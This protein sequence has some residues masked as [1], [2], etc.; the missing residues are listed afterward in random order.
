MLKKINWKNEIQQTAFDLIASFGW[1]I[2]ISIFAAPNEI[3]PGG[4]SGIS[5]LLNYVFGVPIGITNFCFNV[6][7]LIAAYFVLGRKFVVRTLRT[8][9]SYTI[10]TDLLFSGSIITYTYH[11]DP[12]MAAVFGGLFYG[13]STALIFMQ[14]GT[15]GGTDILNRMI[16]H[17]YPYF[18]IGQLSLAMNTVVMCSAA[19]VYH[20][21]DAALYGL[22]FSFVN[23][24]I[25]DTILNGVDMGKCVLIITHHP[26]E[27]ADLIIHDLKRSATILEGTGAYLRDETSILLCV[28]RKQQ[29]YRLKR[30]VA[31]CDP[32]AFVIITDATQIIGQGF[33]PISAE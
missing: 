25:L 14:G 19:I 24:R 27:I 18:S 29:F 26:D 32:K 33:K 8:L 4:F 12:I 16:Q 2:G 15:G 21:I 28:V 23:S 5:V 13:A 30:F 10:F 1:A 11:G 9:I 17:K 3:A 7:L 31:A 22:L 20:K 6:P